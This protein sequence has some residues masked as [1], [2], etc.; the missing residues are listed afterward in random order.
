VSSFRYVF[1]GLSITSSWGNG[2]ATTY[3]ALLHQ[4]AERGHDVTFLERDLSFYAAHRDL[5]APSYAKTEL[6]GSFEE[7]VD[8]HLATVRDADLVVV[9]SYVPEGAR[10]GAWVQE[11]AP[12]R[13]AFY[14]IDTPITL[15]KLAESG[16][17]EYLT[18]AQIARYALYLSF[19]GGPTLDILRNRY[20]AQCVRPLYCSADPDRY[21]PMRVEPSIDLG[22]LGTY[23]ADRQPAVE[24]LLLDTARRSSG[25]HFAV[26]GAQYPDTI[27][28]PENVE[29]TAHLD[30]RDHPHFYASQ[31]FTLNVT[32][33]A[34]V[35][36]GWSPSV[37]LFEAA[38]CGTPVISD[39]WPG[40]DEIFEP[41][42]EILIARSTEDVLR[43]LRDV[44]ED[45]R[46]AMGAAARRRFL[47][48]HTAMHRAESLERYTREVLDQQARRLRTVLP[49]EARLSS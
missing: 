16:E 33:Q 14:D 17:A 34:M 39:P 41:G 3:R 49:S 18:A 42:R 28:W 9:G 46:R 4:L 25:R 20:A 11:V 44:R 43:Y 8:R 31:R 7:L 32:R 22:Y 29:R 27:A 45:Q 19:T 36:A 37:R 35:E 21:F 26:A 48:E 23:S 24:R 40:L 15:A 13:C 10:V 6:Y 47:D 38:A 2:H 1:L 30:P 12:T 5:G